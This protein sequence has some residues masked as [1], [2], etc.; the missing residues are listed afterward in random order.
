MR[1]CVRVR[2]CVRAYNVCTRACVLVCVRTYNVCV[3]ASV[4]LR[5]CVRA[6]EHACVCV[7]CVCVRARS[8]SSMRVSVPVSSDHSPT[9][10]CFS[11][12]MQITK[13]LFHLQAH[14][15]LEARQAK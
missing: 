15:F 1:A 4:L 10:P 14:T 3:R 11:V 5:A 2:A 12:F 7:V 13:Q 8:R 9:T 6:C